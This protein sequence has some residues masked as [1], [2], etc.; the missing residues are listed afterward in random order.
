MGDT[1]DLKLLLTGASGYMSAF[2]IFGVDPILF[3]DLDDS[4]T[5]TKAASEH[6]IVIHTASGFHSGSAK[7]L[8]LGLGER[9]RST[10]KDIYYIH[11]SGTSNVA[12]TPITREY[13]E[14]RVLSDKTDIYSYLQQREL[15]EPYAQ[16]TTDLVVVET[17]KKVGVKTYILMSPTIYGFGTGLFNDQSIQIPQLIRN[18]IKNRYSEVVH[19][20]DL[21]ELYALVLARVLEGSA[22]LPSREEVVIF[23]GTGTYRWKDMAARI[24][25]AGVQLGVLESPEPKSINL[26][27][28]ADKLA[29]GSLQ[30]AELGFASNSRTRANIAKDLGW[31]PKT[32]ADWEK[33]FLEEFTVVLEKSL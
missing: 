4:E 12:D 2:P 29:G 33:N 3:K 6:D 23:T 24:G 26:K 30:L 27:E 22:G 13:L 25:R 19:I 7:A 32:E 5:I 8:I 11:S 15:C 10:G 9:K 18:A 16:R 31:K 17:G 28:T 20:A 14:S 21:A 1:A